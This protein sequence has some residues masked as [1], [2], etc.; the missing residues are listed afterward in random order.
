MAKS[1]SVYQKAGTFLARVGSIAMRN[2]GFLKKLF[3]S[4]FI[5]LLDLYYSITS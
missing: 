3:M 1:S 2:Q 4:N 5:I